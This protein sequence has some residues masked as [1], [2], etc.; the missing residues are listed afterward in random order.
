MTEMSRL[1][2]LF[3][4][5]RNENCDIKPKSNENVNYEMKPNAPAMGSN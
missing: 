1:A 4:Q 3:I 2:R 5:A